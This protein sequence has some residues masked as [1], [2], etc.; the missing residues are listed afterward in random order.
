MTLGET[1]L[2]VANTEVCAGPC[3]HLACGIPAAEW[4]M[5]GDL[6]RKG[7]TDALAEYMSPN[8]DAEVERAMARRKETS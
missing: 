3:D 5:L 8:L 2:V 6:I 7:D 4:D 1:K